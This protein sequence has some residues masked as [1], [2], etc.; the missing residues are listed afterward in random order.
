[1]VVIVKTMTIFVSFF[2]EFWYDIQLVIECEFKEKRFIIDWINLVFN[3]FWCR[4][5]NISTFFR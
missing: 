1:M 2:Y 3:V 5:F 4:E